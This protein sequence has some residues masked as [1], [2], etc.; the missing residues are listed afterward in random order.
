MGKVK[1]D[2]AFKANRWT[3]LKCRVE[4]KL[5]TKK[6]AKNG[7]AARIY[8][9]CRTHAP[10]EVNC[11]VQR[12]FLAEGKSTFEKRF[13]REGREAREFVDAIAQRACTV[14]LTSKRDCANG[15]C[16]PCRSREILAEQGLRADN[17]ESGN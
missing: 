3:T 9:R 14:Y 2:D 4:M 7:M 10:G 6:N 1:R 12:L 13:I 11:I 8:H 16:W 17:E 15:E 5:W